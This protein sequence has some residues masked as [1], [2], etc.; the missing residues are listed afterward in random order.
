MGNIYTTDYQ[1]IG[2][3]LTMGIEGGY[4]VCKSWR[5]S[6]PIPGEGNKVRL[7]LG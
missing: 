3:N 1:A 2:P 6:L 7:G 5:F 4:L